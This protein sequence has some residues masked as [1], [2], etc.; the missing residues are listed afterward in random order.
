MEALKA[1]GGLAVILPAA[2]RLRR[3]GFLA[4]IAWQRLLRG[5]SDDPATLVPLYLQ[6]PV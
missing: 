3:A 1:S 6:H 2:A 4:E 5:E